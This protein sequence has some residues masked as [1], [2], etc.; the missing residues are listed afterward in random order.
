MEKTEFLAER[1]VPSFYVAEGSNL[2]PFIQAFLVWLNKQNRPMGLISQL[3]TI[4]DIDETLDEYL[5][6]LKSEYASGLPLEIAT[7]TRKFLKNVLM[8][9]KSKGSIAS[10]EYFFRTLYDASVYMEYPKEHILKAS[11]G[12][13]YNDY[14]IGC[15]NFDSLLFYSPDGNEKGTAARLFGMRIRAVDFGQGY[16]NGKPVIAKV[17][18]EG[19]ID[20]VQEHYF[21]SYGRMS[22]FRVSAPTGTFPRGKQVLIDYEFSDSRD[23]FISEI[24]G[25]DSGTGYWQGAYGQ[26]SNPDILLQDSYYYQDFSYVLSTAVPFEQWNE[27]LKKLLH[28]AGLKV[29]GNYQLYD[30]SDSTINYWGAKLWLMMVYRQKRDPDGNPLY[31]EDGYHVYEDLWNSSDVGEVTDIGTAVGK[32]TLEFEG[33][34]PGADDIASEESF[35]QYIEALERTCLII[36][37]IYHTMDYGI[38]EQSTRIIEFA[39]ESNKDSLLAFDKNGQYIPEKEVDWVHN[40]FRVPRNNVGFY[41]FMDVLASNFVCHGT[42]SPL[43]V[44]TPL[45]KEDC[46]PD[47]IPLVFYKDNGVWKKYGIENTKVENQAWKLGRALANKEVYIYQSSGLSHLQTGNLVAHQYIT[48]MP[49]GVPLQDVK[50]ENVV[51]FLNGLLNTDWEWVT[52]SIVF[53]REVTGNYEVYLINSRYNLSKF[54]CP[55]GVTF[56][57]NG[58]IEST[59]YPDAK[60]IFSRPPSEFILEDLYDTGLFT[61]PEEVDPDIIEFAMQSNDCSLLLFDKAG[62]Y[63]PE[64]DVDWHNNRF[65][66]IRPV[67]GTYHS[68]DIL[69]GNFNVHCMCPRNGVIEPFESED[70]TRDEIPLVFHY[71]GKIW[72]KLHNSNIVMEDG[73]WKVTG[74]YPGREMYLHQASGLSNYETGSLVNAETLYYEAPSKNHIALFVDGM[75]WPRFRFKDNTL[76]FFRPV[77]GTYEIYLVN[78]RENVSRFYC[79]DGLKLY[80]YGLIELNP[81]WTS[82]VEE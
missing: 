50:K 12:R 11:D 43:S 16:E 61:I 41:R 77:T 8:L 64:K 59:L 2:V 55:D 78:S 47:T 62:E 39:M 15:N 69:S 6:Y 72:R 14:F 51:V 68:V 21:P 76:T 17:Y 54:W 13:W 32:L 57:R 66:N 38:P 19:F 73:V 70:Y 28:P 4:R 67:T 37:E 75:F 24:Y 7:D 18:G 23:Y 33:K 31:D 30:E 9:Y 1:M 60:I 44:L 20:D 82:K 42:L 22:A 10:F 45:E 65:L 52:G 35:V 46:S 58:I 48:Y 3:A 26:I 71:N 56:K 53:P 36:E 25:F 34:F 74:V 40:R 79:E 80:R 29:F 49:Q 81:E 63:V 27:P 5:E